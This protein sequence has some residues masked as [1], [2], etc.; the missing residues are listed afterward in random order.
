MLRQVGLITL[1]AQIGAIEKLTR[2]VETDPASGLVTLRIVD[3]FGELRDR[4]HGL[5]NGGAARETWTIDPNDPLSARGETHWTKTLS[6][7]D[8]SVRTETFTSMRSDA[9]S[10]FLGGR[11]EAYE[12]AELVF[13]RD[14]E[15][16]IP[17]DFI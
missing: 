16:E 11:I 8:W 17:R 3:D 12:G 6:R 2:I 5:A 10:F 7:G 1:L 9:K 4:N 14:F 15:E 13:E